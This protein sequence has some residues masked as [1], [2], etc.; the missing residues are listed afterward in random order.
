MSTERATGRTTR[1]IL[2]TATYLCEGRSTLVIMSN[3]GTLKYAQAELVKVLTGLT[4]QDDVTQIAATVSLHPSAANALFVTADNLQY[5]AGMQYSTWVADG[6][7]SD[8]ELEIVLAGAGRASTLKF[9]KS[10]IIDLTPE[11]TSPPTIEGTK[12]ARRTFSSR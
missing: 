9:I 10:C 12:N 11:V 8:A 5:C 4:Q 1:L 7:L 2:Q 6:E 3:Q